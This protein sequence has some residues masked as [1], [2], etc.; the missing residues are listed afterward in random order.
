[1]ILQTP[2]HLPTPRHPERSEGSGLEQPGH[3]VPGQILRSSR[4]PQDDAAR[5]HEPSRDCVRSMGMKTLLLALL[6]CAVS[7][8]CANGPRPVPPYYG[9]TQ[10]MAQVIGQIN[11]NN[12]KITTLRAGHSFD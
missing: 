2:S 11:A 5:L 6:A 1:M 9:P 4:L 8:G 10:S 12:P 7:S 3:I